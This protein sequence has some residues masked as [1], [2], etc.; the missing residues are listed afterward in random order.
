[1][2]PSGKKMISLHWKLRLLPSL[3]GLLMP[4]NQQAK[5]GVTV[6]AVVIDPDYQVGN[7]TTTRQLSEERTCLEYRRSLVL[8]CPVIKVNGKLKQ[9]LQAEL[10]MAHTLHE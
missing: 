3:C 7:C 5:K 6:L 4:L 1:M 8:P 2:L 10:L 9:P